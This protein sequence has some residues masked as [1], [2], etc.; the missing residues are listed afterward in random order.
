MRIMTTNH[1]G[2]SL[3]VQQHECTCMGGEDKLRDSS[4]TIPFPGG[5]SLI[6]NLPLLTLG[7]DLA[8]TRQR[9]T[10]EELILLV[11]AKDL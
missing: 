4:K 11:W 2:V 10:S 1:Q 7:T 5:G 9:I 3:G 6:F 8:P